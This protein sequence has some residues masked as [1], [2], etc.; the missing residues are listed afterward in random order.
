MLDIEMI[1]LASIPVT[2]LTPC[3]EFENAIRRFG[4]VSACEWF[5]H[6]SNS[7]FTT[8]TIEHLARL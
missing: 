8:D 6:Q 1:K 4:I 2:E 7:E 3:D 5:G